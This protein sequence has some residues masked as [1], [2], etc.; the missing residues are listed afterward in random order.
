MSA[1][2]DAVADGRLEITPGVL[3]NERGAEAATARTS[4]SVIIPAYNAS[5]TIEQAL[6]SVRAPRS[7]DLEA[8]VVDDGSTDATAAVVERWIRRDPRVRLVRQA[9]AGVSAARN[10]GLA[11]AR[12]EWL[13]FLDAD[14]WLAP[15]AL[16][17][18]L[19]LAAANL[20][21]GVVSGAAARV[22]E[23]GRIWPYDGRDLTDAFA[24]LATHCALP[25]HSALVKRSIAL[26]LGGFDETLPSSEDWDFWQRVARAGH[27]FAQTR[28]RVAYYRARAGSL[29]RNLAQSAQHGLVVMRRA[30]A[31]DPRVRNVSPRY[32]D[33]APAD[34]LPTHEFFY[35]LWSAARDIA[36]G[37]NGLAV[38]AK[39][40]DGDH[41]EFSPNDIGELMAGGMADV[42]AARPQDL[43]SHWPEFEPKLARV[44]ELASPSPDHD[45]LRR[46]AISVVKARLN[47]GRAVDRDAI[48]LEDPR[49]PVQIPADEVLLLQLRFRAE[50]L[51]ALAL[52]ALQERSP[53]ELV[54]GIC[55]Q[56]A[57]IP[58]TPALKAARP[59]RI[60]SFWRAAMLRVVDVRGLSLHLAW[61]RPGRL[62]AILSSRLR[63]A[64]AVGLQAAVRA[65]LKP[66]AHGD[67][68]ALVSTTAARADEAPGQL[69]RQEGSAT[70]PAGRKVVWGG[71]ASRILPRRGEVS[72]E[73]PILM[74][75]RITPDLCGSPS[76]QR[77]A[78]APADFE[79]QIARLR[80]AGCWGVTPEELRAALK[81]NRPLPGRPVMITFDDG[82]LDF[83]QQAWPVLQK[84]ELP[85]TLFVI[86]GK[87]GGEADWDRSQ[88]AAAPLLDWQDIKRLAAGGVT[89][90][91][92]GLTHR[93]LTR[94]ALAEVHRELNQSRAS[95]EA[96]TGRRPISICYPFGASDPAVEQLAEDCGYQLGFSVQ[97]AMADLSSNPLRLPRIEISRSDDLNSFERKVGIA[98][99]S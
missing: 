38:A 74:Y 75:H 70:E 22:S 33:G 46:I 26:E 65:R 10:A 6:R 90:E 77:F 52:P 91:S 41:I 28:S 82:Y 58:L 9:H 56:V 69:G 84:H 5:A 95:I 80:Q 66:L 39:I 14:D 93:P 32:A 21:T 96:A 40:R 4:V 24:V 27:R 8:I 2:R 54:D 11:V 94:L 85:A 97:P 51:G 83:L 30:H 81:A 60:P 78:V 25:I 1:R 49:P 15:N 63:H 64:L 92:H 44:L 29:S 62:R 68:C 42:L 72:V 37:G 17:R 43:S 59:W 23:I 61:R 45:R 89:I 31:A 19:A 47:G 50:T 53:A 86:A 71:G 20:Q 16:R 99:P 12:G 13:C 48:Q 7:V 79:A 3:P 98:S 76:L 67:A 88:G 34:E 57:R 35:L 87:V 36:L 73:I 18:L 55:R